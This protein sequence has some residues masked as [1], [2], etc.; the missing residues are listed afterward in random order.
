MPQLVLGEV[1]S[2]EQSKANTEFMINNVECAIKIV[3][4]KHINV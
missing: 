2:V 1:V 4:T 3:G